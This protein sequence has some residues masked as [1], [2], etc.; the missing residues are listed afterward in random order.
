MATHRCNISRVQEGG[1]KFEIGHG[2][3]WSQS[4]SNQSLNHSTWPIVMLNY[5]LPPWLVT[6]RFFIVLV[7]LIPGKESVTS[8]NIDVYLAPLIEELLELWEGVTSTDVSS[9]TENK[10]FSL[11]AM[12]IWYK[13]D[14]P[15]YGLLSG[16]VTKGYKGCPECGPNVSTRRS[17]ALGK[18]VYQGLWEYGF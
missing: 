1:K 16:Q 4:F 5:N 10:T 8:D 17:R 15:A 14:F 13:H 9:E 6:K 2:V 3:G 18:N 11:R 12:L 7:L